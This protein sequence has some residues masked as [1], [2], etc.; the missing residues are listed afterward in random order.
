MY[1]IKYFDKFYIQ[2]S[3]NN[4]LGS[5]MQFCKCFKNNAKNLYIR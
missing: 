2:T 5:S 4:L 3:N 1:F